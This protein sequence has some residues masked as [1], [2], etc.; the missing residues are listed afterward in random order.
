MRT[1]KVV[2]E[3]DVS[4]TEL[5][6]LL[7]LGSAVEAAPVNAPVE[8]VVETATEEPNQFKC[9][10][11]DYTGKS[12]NSVN[13]HLKYCKHKPK[14]DK[15]AKKEKKEKK[16]EKKER[17]SRTKEPLNPFAADAAAQAERRRAAAEKRRAA[18]L[19][20]KK[21]KKEVYKP[22][23]D[24]E[25][26]D[27]VVTQLLA[28]SGEFLTS[29]QI[30]SAHKKRAVKKYGDTVETRKGLEP[31]EGRIANVMRRIE[32]ILSADEVMGM[33]M[34]GEDSYQ[35]GVLSIEN[36]KKANLLAELS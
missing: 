32:S 35:L 26:N 21:E 5:L 18:L 29:G 12:Q 16:K 28:R 15:K 14:K 3:V 11:C 9:P 2:I 20:K 10:Y 24:A 19:E 30:A 25:V 13:S 8:T 17:K 23:T 1:I 27:L 6:A 33:D 34:T 22:P 36:I 31:L 4:D 7:G